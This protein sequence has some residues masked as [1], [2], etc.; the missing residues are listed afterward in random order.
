[1]INSMTAF[2]KQDAKEQGIT[3]PAEIKTLNGRYLEI[4][5]KL[6]KTLSDKEFEIREMLKTNLTR[7]SVQIFVNI[8]R[9]V[10]EAE[11][12]ID[13]ELA[14][15]C[16]K[17]LTELKTKLAIKQSVNLDH[18]LTLSSLFLKKVENNSSNL[19]WKL[20][21]I[22]VQ[23]AIKSIKKMRGAEGQ[24]ILKDFKNRIKNI[25][26]NLDKIENIAIS[27]IKEERE[28]LRQKIYQLFENDEIDE[29]RIQQEIV[30]QAN[31]LDISEECVRLRSHIKFF[32]E[33][34]K[35]KDPAGQ[36]INFLLQEMNREVNTIGS[37]AENAELSHIVV[38]L[39]EEIEKI[40]EQVQNI[41]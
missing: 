3:V 28:R 17:S 24:Q 1:M 19:D 6:P 10:P 13:K 15:I 14:A 36:K 5:C 41:E 39:K 16:K 37:K 26:D 31:K 29:S 35:Q 23:E 30:I 33:C 4:T 11:F 40:R 20:T 2:S 32:N 22:A 8:E 7:G 27:R 12:T 18:L 25:T 9:N 21:K 38:F 34:L